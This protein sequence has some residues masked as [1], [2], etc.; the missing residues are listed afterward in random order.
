MKHDYKVLKVK[1]IIEMTLSG[2]LNP[3]PIAQ[4]PA[5]SE[6][7]TKSQEIIAA[8]LKDLGVGM[9]TVRDI[10]K[11]KEMQKV[12]PGVQYIVIDGGHRIR[13]LKQFYTNEL[14]VNGHYA[15]EHDHDKMVALYNSELPMHAIVCTS[16]EAIDIFRVL[17]ET[18][19]VNFMEMIMCDDQS[20]INSLIRKMTK[21]YREYGNNDVHLIFEVKTNQKG[22]RIPTYWDGAPNPRRKWDE[23]VY[24]AF[25]KVIGGGNV[26]AGTAEIRGLYESEYQEVNPINKRMIET[27]IRF[28]NDLVAFQCFRYKKLNKHIFA[29]LQVVWFALYERNDNFKIDD[30][31]KFHDQFMYAYSKLTGTAD[32][33]YNNKIV[34]IGTENEQHLVPLKEWVRDNITNFSNSFAQRTAAKLIM[35]EMGEDIGVIMRDSVRSLRTKER[36]EMLALQGYKCALDGERLTLE[37]SVWGHDVAWANGGKLYD[38]KVVRRIHN[39]AMGQ[40]TLDEYKL[41]LEMRKN[42]AA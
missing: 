32:T 12:Y 13:A 29:A 26:D 10:S 1:E 14:K 8:M 25:L 31:E 17:N 33:T 39:T 22:E 4:R 23:Y 27:V 41:I 7:P 5:T 2:K 11:D 20:E 3:D 36:E 38:G 34:N 21:S 6:S 18:T 16:M 19:H 30:M 28:F 35:K 24:I 9:I 37:D 15:T 42:K 40:L